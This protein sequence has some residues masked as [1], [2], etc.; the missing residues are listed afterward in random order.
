M[1][2]NN[3][4]SR[5]LDIVFMGTPDFATPALSALH[6]LGESR[7]NIRL[8]ATQPDR[9]S[10]RGRK[11]H[12]PPVKK[13]ALDMGYPVAQP[14]SADSHAFKVQLAAYS[15]DLLVVVAY[16]QILKRDVL[17]I[18]RLGAVNIHASL[19]PRYRGPAPIQRAIIDRAPETGVTTMLLD[20]GMDTGDILLMR[21]TPIARDETA[22]DLH[23]RLAG[24][25]AD[26]L[27]ETIDAL[28]D[29][30]ATPRPQ[31]PD[32][33]TYAPM[34]GKEDGHIDWSADAETIEALIRGVTPWPGAFTFH[35]DRRLRIFRASLATRDADALPGAVIPGFSDE[36]R[37]AAGKDALSI[38]EIQGAS[39]KRMDIA[40]FLR[41]HDLP[42]GTRFK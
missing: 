17:R 16:G 11:R 33:A 9:R 39:G 41:G 21:M 36:L 24:M 22:G 1:N 6:S 14:E 34:L 31:D 29:G 42:V 38:L 8:V 4:P 35:G 10:G 26:L 15:P 23:D 18:P 30:T 19:L 5:P 12:P 32:A 2:R 13:A 7:C 3:G 25:G 37:V 40:S 20:E 27:L 28:Q